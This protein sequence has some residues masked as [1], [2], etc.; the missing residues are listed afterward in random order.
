VI[1]RTAPAPPRV[2]WRM[3]LVAVACLALTGCLWANK[4]SDS[5][6]GY[7]GHTVL[8][9]DGHLEGAGAHAMGGYAGGYAGFDASLRDA[10]RPGDRDHHPAIG[11]GLSARLS[12]FG[13]MSTDHALERYL[14]LGGEAGGG[15]GGVLGAGPYRVS[16]FGSAWYGAWVD[17]G[18]VSV[19]AGYLALTGGIRRE[20]F[21]DPWNDRTQLMIGLAWRKR[22]PITDAELSWH[23]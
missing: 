3:K 17:I 14:D 20:A 21:T 16:G 12:L 13:V 10:D 2:A 18:T 8:G 4:Q 15:F 1:G 23:D 22:E 11:L 7:E 19:G 5:M 6:V 9:D